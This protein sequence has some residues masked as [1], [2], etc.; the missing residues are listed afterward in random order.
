MAAD[1]PSIMLKCAKK[2]S[3]KVSTVGS[4]LL[5]RSKAYLR[6]WVQRHAEMRKEEKHKSVYRG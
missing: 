3:T 4:E 6:T 5:G 2:K 1:G